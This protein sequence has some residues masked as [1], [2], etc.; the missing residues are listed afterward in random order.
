MICGS[1]EIIASL[2]AWARHGPPAARVDQVL[3]EEEALPQNLGA[4][5]LADSA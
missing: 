3:V 5:H 2:I 1:P 4:F